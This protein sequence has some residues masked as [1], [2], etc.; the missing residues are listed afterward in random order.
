MRAAF[1]A[2]NRGEKDDEF[3]HA[4]HRE[5]PLFM[6]KLPA[7]SVRQNTPDFCL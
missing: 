4:R 1:T 5:P 7:I 6:I 3:Y 2:G